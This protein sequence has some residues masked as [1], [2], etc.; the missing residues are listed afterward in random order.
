[1]SDI[2]FV[3]QFKIQEPP[4]QNLNFTAQQPIIL[5]TKCGVDT[6]DGWIQVVGAHFCCECVRKVFMLDTDGGKNENS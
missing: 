5:C 1:M 3:E 6:K 4:D 2:G